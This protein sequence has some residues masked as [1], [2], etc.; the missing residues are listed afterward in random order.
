MKSMKTGHRELR[1]SLFADLVDSLQGDDA[2]TQWLI[3]GEQA[4]IDF[5]FFLGSLRG[6][7]IPTVW[8]PHDGEQL[9]VPHVAIIAD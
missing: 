1:D 3:D 7:G 4:G 9:P 5:E 2:G 8:S 6:P